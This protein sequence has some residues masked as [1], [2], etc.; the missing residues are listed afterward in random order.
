MKEITL[1]LYPSKLRKPDICSFYGDKAMC[2]IAV[3]MARDIMGSIFI[4]KK[5]IKSDVISRK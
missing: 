2:V 4:T 5:N 1:P 3:L